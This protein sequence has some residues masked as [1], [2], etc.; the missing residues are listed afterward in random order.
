MVICDKESCTGC[1]ACASVC[2][3]NAII[4]IE[5]DYGFIHPYVDEDVCVSC[6]RCAKVC[7]VNVQ[8]KYKQTDK[9]YACWQLDEKKRFEATS[10]GAF[11]TIAEKFIADGG[12]VYGAAFDDDFV[13]RHIRVNN[14]DGL[15]RLRGSKYV[16]SATYGIFESVKADLQND[17]RVLFS[18]TPCQVSAL[19]SYLSK[20]FEG[21]Y[22][23]DIV[24]HGVPSPSVFRDYLAAIKEKYKKEITS[25]NFRYKNP[26]WSVYSMRI[27]FMDGQE[28]MA[29]KFKDPFLFFFL[30]GEET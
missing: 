18:G 17:I 20:D 24:C 27:Q 19:K 12:V 3:K 6:G 8:L 15:I 9:I 2:N 16:Q 7:P 30:A 10:G 23:I 4:P 13:V 26:C 25:V 22:T 1:M 29:D 11:L 21:L 28:Y 14:A 5:D